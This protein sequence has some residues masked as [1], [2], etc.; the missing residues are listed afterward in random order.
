MTEEIN[1]VDCE[2]RK[3]DNYL[4][5]LRLKYQTSDQLVRGEIL[6]SLERFVG[7][8]LLGGY[9]EK[10]R[11]YREQKVILTEAEKNLKAFNPELAT[12]IRKIAGFKQI[13]LA[14]IL[15]VSQRTI[16]GYETGIQARKAKPGESYLSYLR[17]LKEV[18]G[19]N[20]FNL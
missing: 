13:E 3:F 12:R 8:I 6:G 18:S 16:S 4:E 11:E 1:P 19:Y 20:P 7:S 5:V 15:S 2:G 10:R 9:A 14:D 17:W